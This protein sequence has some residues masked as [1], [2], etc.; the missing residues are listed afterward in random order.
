MMDIG[1]VT[2][3]TSDIPEEISRREGIE[4]IPALINIH[5][6]SYVDGLEISRE[7]FYSRL[8]DINPLPTTSTP[9]VG[10]FQERYEGLFKRGVGTIL[11]IH[12][13]DK[14]SGIYNAARLAAQDF[15]ERV[16]V[17]DSGQ[18]SLGL[19]FQVLAAVEAAA[20]GTHFQE[21]L[22]VVLLQPLIE[23]RYGIV[24]RL[25]QAR[26]P[27]Q[28]VQRLVEILNGWG[29]LER[30]AI[31]HTNAEAAARALLEQVGDRVPVTPLLV[32]VTTVIGTHVGPGG[33]GFA[34]VPVS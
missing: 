18:L 13:P 26:T 34:A 23:L 27:A 24:Q 6:R 29:P 28:G 25:G 32:N 22:S 11:S 3:S 16:R 30:L 5:G 20:R 31:L 33:L 21:L 8:P 9:S 12:P 15:G 2:D 4:V 7:D 17:L 10:A 1:I 19:G 14:L